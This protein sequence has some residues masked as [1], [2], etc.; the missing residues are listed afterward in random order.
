MSVIFL[1]IVELQ[2]ALIYLLVN[3]CP[4]SQKI[5]LSAKPDFYPS[6]SIMYIIV[7]ARL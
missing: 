7:R 3:C 2:C 6:E 4:L 5:L 1:D